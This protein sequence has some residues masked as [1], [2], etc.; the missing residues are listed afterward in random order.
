MA[1]KTTPFQGTKFRYQTGKE[2]SKA[3]TAVERGRAVL[4]IASSGFVKGDM[5]EI[6]G[7]E[8]FNGLY[9]VE[10]V[11]SDKVTLSSEVDWSNKDAPT[12]FSQAKASKIIFSQQVCSIT[13]ID[14]SDN[15]LSTEDITT[16]CS[17]GTET[18][19]GEIEFGSLKLDFFYSASM[20]HQ[21]AF[22]KKFFAKETFAY[23]LE[24][25]AEQG[26]IFGV[27]FLESAGSFSAEIKGKFKGSVSIKPVKRD[28]LLPA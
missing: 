3:I 26:T 12:N 24:L 15:T 18:E 22:R 20:P 17:E 27:G 11:A 4:T 21:V 9:P 28:Y 13:S 10:S 5:I 1:T 7:L 8:G 6:E 19:P 2:A 23:K 16:I 14:K 25:T